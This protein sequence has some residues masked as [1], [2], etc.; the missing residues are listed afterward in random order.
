MA[1][2]KVFG[3][4]RRIVDAAFVQGAVVVVQTSVGPTALGMSEKVERSHERWCDRSSHGRDLVQSVVLQPIHQV[5]HQQ[6]RIQRYRQLHLDQ[7]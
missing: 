4:K 2:T 1:G 3:H 5:D 6:I 7:T